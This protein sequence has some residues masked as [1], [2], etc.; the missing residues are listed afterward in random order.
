MKINL[1]EK[2][3]KQLIQESIFNSLSNFFFGNKE[4]EKKEP[5]QKINLPNFGRRRNIKIAEAEALL[6]QKITKDNSIRSIADLG[7]INGRDIYLVIDVLGG[8]RVWF[9]S[10]SEEV[11]VEMEGFGIVPSHN[12][13]LWFIKSHWDKRPYLDTLEE[14]IYINFN[15]WYSGNILTNELPFVYPAPTNVY[16][17]DPEDDGSPLSV[18]QRA[19]DLNKQLA[20]AGFDVSLVLKYLSDIKQAYVSGDNTKI[21]NVQNKLLT[22]IG[23]GDRRPSRFDTSAYK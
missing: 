2:E 12:N 9:E 10:M 11:P 23:Y 17:S 14:L 15:D 5:V 6:G 18:I 7:N 3:L 22:D 20:K 13:K 21:L 19:V 4:K 16:L 1:S 8:H